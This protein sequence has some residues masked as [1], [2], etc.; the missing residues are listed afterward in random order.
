MRIA[1]NVPQAHRRLAGR[2]CGGENWMGVSLRLQRPAIFGIPLSTISK[3]GA[4]PSAFQLKCT[5]FIS[6]PEGGTFQEPPLAC[7]A[8]M[9]CMACTL[10]SSRNV[11]LSGNCLHVYSAF[12]SDVSRAWL[13]FIPEW[14]IPLA[15]V[16]GIEAHSPLRARAGDFL[17]VECCG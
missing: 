9:A 13:I 15:L 7:A 11:P 3:R 14:G 17:F 4:A 8:C 6:P 10:D 2:V 5:L 12:I 1:L 16:G